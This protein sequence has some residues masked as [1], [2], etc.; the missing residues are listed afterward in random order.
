MTVA[1]PFE[2]AGL[3]SSFPFLNETTPSSLRSLLLHAAHTNAASAIPRC[4]AHRIAHRL[5]VHSRR[6]GCRRLC[7]VLRSAGRGGGGRSVDA[8]QEAST[9]RKRRRRRGGSARALAIQI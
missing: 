4:Y 1:N 3:V 6:C 8:R 5:A 2:V 9:A 7:P